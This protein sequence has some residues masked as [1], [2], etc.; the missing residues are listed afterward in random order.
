MILRSILQPA[1]EIAPQYE[2]WQLKLANGE[3]RVGFLLG[4]KGG[5]SFF[6]DLTGEEFEISYK[7][8]VEREQVPTSMMPPGL[9]NTMSNQEAASLLKWLSTP[10]RDR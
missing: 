4:Q 8:I 9:L 5:A 7:D 3:T 1:A 2:A 10:E 6:S